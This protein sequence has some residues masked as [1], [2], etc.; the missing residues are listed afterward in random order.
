M[1][2]GIDYDTSVKL[3]VKGMILSNINANMETRERILKILDGLGG[4]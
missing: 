1:S 3:I 2:R 4:D